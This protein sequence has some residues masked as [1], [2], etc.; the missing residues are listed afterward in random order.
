MVP[1]LKVYSALYFKHHRVRLLSTDRVAESNSLEVKAFLLEATSSAIIYVPGQK[2][3]SGHIHPCVFMYS[4]IV[5]SRFLGD[6]I[7]YGITLC[8]GSICHTSLPLNPFLT[9]YLKQDVVSPLLY[10]RRKQGMKL[11]WVAQG[12]RAGKRLS[13]GLYLSDLTVF[14]LPLTH[15][16]ASETLFFLSHYVHW[17]REPSNR[18]VLMISWESIS[19][20]K[21]CRFSYN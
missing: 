9:A 4:K 21:P 20:G 3:G 10:K 7:C 18:P 8:S 5:L 13:W 15:P 6:I 1:L 16:W 2:R 14:P 11:M 17:V 19:E 12:H